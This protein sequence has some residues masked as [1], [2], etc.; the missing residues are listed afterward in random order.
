MKQSNPNEGRAVRRIILSASALAISA[1]AAG[2]QLGQ[3]FCAG[4]PSTALVRNNSFLLS[5]PRRLSM[6]LPDWN[7]SR[8]TVAP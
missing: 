1:I 4:R 2:E 5:N 6:R 8:T 3:L 7:S